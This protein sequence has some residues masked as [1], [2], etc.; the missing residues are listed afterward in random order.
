VETFKYSLPLLSFMEDSEI[1]IRVN[2]PP[3]LKPEFELALTKVVKQFVRRIRFML[4]DEVLS[5]SKLTKEQVD[6]LADE[7]KERVAKRHKL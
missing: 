5:K 4:A 2:I 3:E 6:E 1:L 7:L